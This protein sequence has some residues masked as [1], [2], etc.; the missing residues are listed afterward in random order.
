MAPCLWSRS[1]IRGGGENIKVRWRE[2]GG[3][4]RTVTEVSCTAAASVAQRS[5]GRRGR[6]SLLAIRCNADSSQGYACV[7]SLTDGS[8]EDAL[9][10]WNNVRPF[11]LLYFDL[12]WCFSFFTVCIFLSV[13]GTFWSLLDVN[14]FSCTFW[15]SRHL[16]SDSDG[17]NRPLYTWRQHGGSC[18][19]SLPTKCL[20]LRDVSTD[21]FII[22]YF[23]SS[24]DPD[25]AFP[26]VAAVSSDKECFLP[27]TCLPGSTASLQ[28]PCS[29]SSASL[30]V[31]H[32]ELF[33]YTENWIN[34]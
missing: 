16:A 3:G 26:H 2:G 22:G 4:E 13:W 27:D 33:S 12:F 34:L 25:A 20:I 31:V 24:T 1:G 21:F 29:L 8:I 30:S 18:G 9:R 32:T 11:Y 5:G 14:I 6:F 15:S 28:T 19:D 7:A 17:L 10:L 23:D